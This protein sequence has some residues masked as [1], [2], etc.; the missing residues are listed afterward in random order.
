MTTFVGALDGPAIT[1]PEPAVAATLESGTGV[2][3]LPEVDQ[4]PAA[5]TAPRISTIR[6]AI[7]TRRLRSLRACSARIAAAR[8]ARPTSRLCFDIRLSPDL[9]RRHAAQGTGHRRQP[10]PYGV[11]RR[12]TPRRGTGQRPGRSPTG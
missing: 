3:L 5:T 12:G 4:T 6:A 10:A 11:A 8:S 1:D 9:R 7:P 2:P